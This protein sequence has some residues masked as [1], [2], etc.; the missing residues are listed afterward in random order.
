MRI[1]FLVLGWQAVIFQPIGCGF[2]GR[3]CKHPPQSALCPPLPT[4]SMSVFL[5]LS[6]LCQEIN[7]LM[8]KFWWVHKENNFRIHWMKCERMGVSKN[9]GGLGFRDLTTLIKPFLLSKCG[10]YF[11]SQ[12]LWWEE[13]LKLNITLLAIF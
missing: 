3:K 13:S 11:N 12:T 2:N 9:K 8:Q 6:S 4:Y 7:R 5:L 1:L 10:D